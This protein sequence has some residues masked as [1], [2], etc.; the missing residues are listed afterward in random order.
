MTRFPLISIRSTDRGI[1]VE[2]PS[3]LN[4]F[5]EVTAR[6]DDGYHEIETLFLALDT[7]DAMVVEAD[8]DRRGPDQISVTGFDA[9]TD[10]TNLA[11]RAVALARSTRPI[12]AVRVDLVK[13]IPA[14]AGLGGG[15]ANAAGMLAILDFWFPDPRGVDGVRLDAARL[16][17]D[18]AFFLG[19]DAAAIG[20]GRGELLEGLR[21]GKL[22]GGDAPAFVIVLPR[23]HSS[24]PDAYREVSLALTSQSGP[25]TFPAT[26]FE[27][28]GEWQR[29][30]FNRLEAP[31]LTS[32]PQLAELARHLGITA[33]PGRAS[34]S[35][36]SFAWS[37]AS[38]PLAVRMTGSGSA[39]FVAGRDL[40]H[41]R[42]I[43]AALRAPGG[44]LEAFEQHTGVVASTLCARPHPHFL[45]RV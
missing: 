35:D 14:G 6:R 33:H 40:A 19:D 4:L 28:S 24:T 2:T 1:E 25:I 43:D 32:V 22:F 42:Q 13:R 18:V 31:V 44:P 30:L 8:S 11:L 7:G 23:V 37:R 16:G 9:P 29:G 21:P 41:A 20:R 38:E 39:F 15:S 26:T 34:E 3:K 12:P 45:P 10:A 27:T 5:L 17:S 36:P